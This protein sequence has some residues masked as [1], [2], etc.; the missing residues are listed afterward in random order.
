MGKNIGGTLGAPMEWHR[1]I[2]N[3]TFYEQELG[4]EPLPNDDLDIQLLWLIAMEEQGVR[5][6]ARTMGDYWMKHITPH[7]AEYGAA[8]AN[9]KAGLMP[10]LS[11]IVENPFKDSCGSYIRSEIWA[12]IAPGCPEQAARFAY[13]D[14]IIDHG[15]GEGVYGEIFCATFES[16]AF[17]EKD[18]NKLIDIGLSYIPEDCDVAKAIALVR[19]MHSDG[20]PWLETRDELIRNFNG[21]FHFFVS[22]EEKAKGFG[23][24]EVGKEVAANVAI[25]VLGLLYGEGDFEKSICTAVNCGEDTDCTAATLGSMLGIIHGY[26]WIPKKWIEPIGNSIKTLTLNLGDI[27]GSVPKDI[28]NL[29][30]RVEKLAFQVLPAYRL[31]V[32]LSFDEKTDLS[33]CGSLF[34][35]ENGKNVC[36]FMDG[37]TYKFDFMNVYV[38]YGADGPIV[39]DDGT[40]KIRLVL[41]NTYFFAEMVNIRWYAAD[42]FDVLPSRNARVHLHHDMSHAMPTD[43][44]N[45]VKEVEFELVTEFAPEA[46]N[47][48]VIE[49][50]VEGN[51][52][53]MLV[54]VVLL[55]KVH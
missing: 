32:T 29:S 50:T 45:G 38:D 51:A 25:V 39:S 3:V 22:E 35:T 43:V 5:I 14:A 13:E 27:G 52:T 42:G 47:R 1:K 19:K 10:P 53:V 54:P 4:G 46:T 2:N 41:K 36:K 11:G 34:A 28:E 17:V 8:K 40:K 16:A 48:F 21:G 49:I 31:P 12:C 7:W 30:E 9:M 26:D 37:P 33:D 20:K 15:D 44:F 24:G 55:C 23:G 6:N 18:I